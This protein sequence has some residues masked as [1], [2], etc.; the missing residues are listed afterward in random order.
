M[1]R[2]NCWTNNRLKQSDKTRRETSL[3]PSNH[4]ARSCDWIGAGYFLLDDFM[5]EYAG[6]LGPMTLDEHS[7]AQCTHGVMPAIGFGMVTSEVLIA[8]SEGWLNRLRHDIWLWVVA[9][10]LKP[11]CEGSS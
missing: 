4:Q 2:Q 10:P 1:P 8:L 3:L 5:P 9:V 11:G 6:E 7:P